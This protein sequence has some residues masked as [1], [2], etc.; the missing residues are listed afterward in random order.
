MNISLS[1]VVVVV[2]FGA[3]CMLIKSFVIV[4]DHQYDGQ[5]AS[6]CTVVYCADVS[7]RG[8]RLPFHQVVGYFSFVPVLEK[9]C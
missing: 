1:V 6:T 3:R 2:V 9:P 8:R 5:D 7:G 4:I